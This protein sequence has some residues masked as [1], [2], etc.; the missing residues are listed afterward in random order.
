VQ[1]GLA[2]E[3][4]HDLELRERDAHL[5]QVEVEASGHPVVPGGSRR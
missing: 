4:E 1:V 5:E 3:R 2:F